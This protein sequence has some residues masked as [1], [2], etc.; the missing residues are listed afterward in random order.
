MRRAYKKMR[1]LRGRCKAID[2]LRWENVMRGMIRTIL[3]LHL[4]PDLKVVERQRSISVGRKKSVPDGLESPIERLWGLSIGFSMVV[5]CWWRL[6]ANEGLGRRLSDWN[7][8]GSTRSYSCRV[9][10]RTLQSPESLL[11][12]CHSSRA[13][14]KVRLVSVRDVR[15]CASSCSTFFRVFCCFEGLHIG[16][17]NKE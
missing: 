11:S 5:R 17:A 14:P 3:K 4:C 16:P 13:F 6:L 15:V 2:C 7:S 10:D 8:V 12:P 1:H 9:H